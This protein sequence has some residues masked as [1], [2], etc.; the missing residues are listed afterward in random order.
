MKASRVGDFT[1]RAE[2]EQHGEPADAYWMTLRALPTTPHFGTS[3]DNLLRD[4]YIPALARSVA[5]DRGVGYFTSNWLRLAASGLAALAANGGRARII[6]SPILDR[7]D[8]AAIIEGADA[9]NDPVLKAAL[10]VAIGDL[11]ENLA[12]DTLS[13]LAWMI[14]DGLLEF[15]VALPTAALDG[16]FHDKFGIFRDQAGDAV[17]FHGSPNDSAKAFRNYESVSVY[18]SW[19]DDREA[20]RVSHEQARFDL[21][22]ENGDANLRVYPL[23]DAVRRNLVAFT[24]QTPRPYAPPNV[25]DTDT[26]RWRHQSDAAGAF[27]KARCGI[28][29][30]ATGTGKTRTALG[31]VEELRTRGLV[32][33]VVVAAY[34][35]D[36]LDQWQKELLTHTSLPIFRAYEQHREAQA[37]LNHPT[38]SILL[39]SRQNLAAVLPR[40]RPAIFDKG[41]LICDEVHGLGSP[42]LVT[43]LT[44]RLKPFAYRL[45]LSATPE[46]IY[47][48]AGEAFI[49]DEIGPVIFRFTLQDA[50]ERGI[51]CE[52]DYVELDYV[53]SD[54]DRA[55]VRQAIKRHHAKTRAGEVRPVEALYREIAF[56]R[57]VSAEKVPPFA[58]YLTS[59][60]EILQRCIIFVETAEF[61]AM[62]QPLLM[63]HRIDFHTYYQDDDRENLR[64]FARGDLQCLLTCHRISEGIDIRSVNNIVLFASSRARLE[65]VQR[66]GRCLRV[67]PSHPEKRARVVDL[68]Q[69]TPDDVDDPTDELSADE[70]RRDW[71]VDLA[72]LRRHD[73]PDEAKLGARAGSDF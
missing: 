16:D 9:R 68:V 46:R 20:T 73:A 70:E 28:L 45:G 54:E 55:A 29:E 7:N 59:H 49:A 11:A 64:L 5:Y 4:L 42:A 37:F 32:E 35:T 21:I 8:C 18:Y 24:H 47:D 6:A 62:I 2:S 66:L 43:A 3:T 61:G 44:G 58:D 41:M 13:A 72:K 31:I 60:P 22:W 40:L 12:G 25:A 19:L 23:P 51:L 26:D 10:D 17:A 27:F 15:R 67:D 38:E 69:T 71:L 63:A 14:A 39:T 48:P 36:L 65:T 50:I 34:G 30:M 56:I 57:K 52:F 1:K 33:T 53:L